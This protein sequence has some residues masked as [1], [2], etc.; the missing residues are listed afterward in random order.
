MNPILIKQLTN[1]VRGLRLLDLC[2][3]VGI[4]QCKIRALHL[5]R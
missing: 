3:T 5:A 1:S 4:N 2:P